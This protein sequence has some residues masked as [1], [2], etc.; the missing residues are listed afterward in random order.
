MKYY[1]F[2]AV[3]LLFLVMHRCESQSDLCTKDVTC[4]CPNGTVQTCEYD[5]ATGI[6]LRYLCTNMDTLKDI[7]CIPVQG[8]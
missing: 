5:A 2:I 7:L 1:G 3:L 4:L 8:K 6:V